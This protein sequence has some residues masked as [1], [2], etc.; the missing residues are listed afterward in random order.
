MLPLFLSFV[1]WPSSWNLGTLFCWPL[2]FQQHLFLW[3]ISCHQVWD[4]CTSCPGKDSSCYQVDHGLSPAQFSKESAP[5]GVSGHKWYP[6]WYRLCSSPHSL[7]CFCRVCS[8]SFQ[9]YFA[10]VVCWI[11][12]SCSFQ[13][14]RDLLTQMFHSSIY[15]VE[16]LGFRWSKTGWI[17]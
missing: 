14:R 5:L 3:Y 16:I 7:W 12:P 9:T 2:W 15:T 4:W 8:F 10:L 13:K 6:Y 17:L 11:Q 1:V